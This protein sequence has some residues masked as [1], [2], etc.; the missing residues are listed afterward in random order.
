MR[1]SRLSQIDD[2]SILCEYC[3]TSAANLLSS[4]S[5][6]V[7]EDHCVWCQRSIVGCHSHSLP[8]GPERDD[9]ARR[10][11]PRQIQPANRVCYACW[12]AARRNVQRAQQQQLMRMAHM[13]S[14]TPPSPPQPE[15]STSQSEPS[16]SQPES[17]TLQ[18]DPRGAWCQASLA[19][20]HSHSL[21]EG[22]E[23]D[24]IA[25]RISPR[26]ITT[27]SRVCYRCWLSARRNSRSV[28]EEVA[29]ASTDNASNVMSLTTLPNFRRTSN[30]ERS[31]FVHGCINVERHAVPKF[32]SPEVV[33]ACVVLDNLCI[34]L[35]EVEPPDDIVI[36]GDDGHFLHIGEQSVE[37]SV[38]TT[39]VSSV[40]S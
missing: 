40:F 28:V 17:S 26:L 24:Y 33:V 38:R 34:E 35:D 36:D 4:E 9:I 10:I 1:R 6:A 39:I 32:L 14:S 20:R 3:F 29:D 37:T 8:N 13:T 25:Q 18:D 30:S 19:R 2:N 11:L 5:R 27:H 23:R 31:C 12:L 22:P 7:S 21:P 15:P 16:T